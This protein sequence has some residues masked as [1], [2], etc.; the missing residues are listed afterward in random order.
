[1]GPDSIMNPSPRIESQRVSIY[2]SIFMLKRVWLIMLVNPSIERVARMFT[3]A[4]EA[5]AGVP[6]DKGKIL[7]SLTEVSCI[8]Y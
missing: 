8:L 5:R 3:N 7:V 1:M 6:F 2:C 4:G